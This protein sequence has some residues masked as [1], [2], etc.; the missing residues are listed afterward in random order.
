[1]TMLASLMGNPGGFYN[2]A[3]TFGGILVCMGVLVYALFG[4]QADTTSGRIEAIRARRDKLK[5]AKTRKDIAVKKQQAKPFVSDRVAKNLV[6]QVYKPKEEQL[7]ELAT[8][9]S[10][11]GIRDR[12]AVYRH[13]FFKL[14][15]TFLAPVATFLLIFFLLKP[16]WSAS[17]SLMV[18]GASAVVGLML[19]DI[20]LNHR[21]QKRMLPIK[22]AFPDALDMMV[23]CA[24]S[25]LSIDAAIKRVSQEMHSGA[26]ELAEE[27]SLTGVELGFFEDRR[28]ALNGL[29]K[30]V[31]LPTVR[32]FVNTMIQTEKYGTPV[33]QSLRV[34]SAEFRQE[35]MM[36]AEAKASQLPAKLTVPLILCI[37]PPLMIVLIG[38]AILQ[39]MDAFRRTGVN[40]PRTD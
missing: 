7:S 30:R 21:T 31:N 6:D 38:P 24:E 28:E 39:A 5:T 10:R 27:L 8:K 2:L 13:M 19:P 26:P 15:W 37:L 22:R 25:G 3:L 9:L 40:K 11:A 12:G 32:A 29:A 36:E 23:V 1:M 16:E 17:T 4:A 14:L 20:M 34:L 35:R 18:V 33:A